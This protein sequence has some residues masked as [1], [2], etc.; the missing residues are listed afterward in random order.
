MK[1]SLWRRIQVVHVWHQSELAL[2][3]VML[4]HGAVACKAPPAM[5]VEWSDLA[6]HLLRLELG[7]RGHSTNDSTT[8]CTACRARS[9]ISFLC[10]IS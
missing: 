10:A 8:G 1:R 9:I 4:T 3:W 6:G 2:V 7:S 5:P